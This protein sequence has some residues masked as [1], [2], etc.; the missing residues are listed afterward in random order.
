MNE[1]YVVDVTVTDTATP[2]P[3][4]AVQQVKIY[5]KDVNERPTWEDKSYA[6]VEEIEN[7]RST[8]EPFEFVLPETISAGVF[9]GNVRVKDVENNTLHYEFIEFNGDESLIAA[10]QVSMAESKRRKDVLS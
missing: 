6:D 10:G 3:N 1:P 4:T 8:R 9:V 5:V 2:I 7:I